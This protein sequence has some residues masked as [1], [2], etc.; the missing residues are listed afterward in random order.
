MFDTINVDS[1]LLNFL[2][3]D[4]KHNL[5]LSN[6]YFSF[7]TKDLENL[8]WTYTI[9]GNGQL[10]LL[11]NHLFDEID[12]DKEPQLP[13]KIDL[14]DYID[15][16]DSF[17]TETHQVFL[18]LRAHIISGRLEHIYVRTKEETLISD[19]EERIKKNS[20]YYS[21]VELQHE[22]KLFR[23]LQKTETYIYK[24]IRPLRNFYTNF[25]YNLKEIAEKKA[26]NEL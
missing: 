20:A 9:K 12:G 6:N 14:T 4:I 10:Y 11:K 1:K 15:F 23:L 3:E 24:F 19:E 17:T 8:L 25:K 22:M 2:D 21:R 5:L 26:K 7:Q 18:T 13:E 16:Y